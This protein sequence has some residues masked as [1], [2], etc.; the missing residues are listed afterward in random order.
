MAHEHTGD[1]N[2]IGTHLLFE[3][4]RIRVWQ[5]LLEPGQEAP[6]HTHDNDYTTYAIE[7][8]LVERPNGDGTVDRI[9]VAPG[10]VMR[11]YQS[12]PRHGLR[13]VGTKTFRNLIFELKDVPAD[14]D[15]LP[16]RPGAGAEA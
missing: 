15:A 7:G 5:I 12:T 14:F 4:E 8:D 6:V 1:A 13:N 10:R 16:G 11:W 3:D 9:T 2:P